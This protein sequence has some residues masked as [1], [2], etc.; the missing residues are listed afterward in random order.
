MPAGARSVGSTLPT[1]K[2]RAEDETPEAEARRAKRKL[3][4]Q[5]LIEGTPFLLDFQQETGLLG[6]FET[7]VEKEM[8]E[9]LED[10]FVV[11][12]IFLDGRNPMTDARTI[13]ELTTGEISVFRNVFNTLEKIDAGEDG[14]GLSGS[15]N[16]KELRKALL[17][18]KILVTEEEAKIMIDTADTDGNGTVRGRLCARPISFL[19]SFRLTR[20]RPISH[21]RR[22]T[23]TSSSRAS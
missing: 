10:K 16:A 22:S 3:E 6:I 2:Q 19:V 11:T 4:I 5:K 1:L 18:V 7:R 23:S 15:I 12:P 20:A 17:T 9:F 8:R 13:D 21:P 14:A